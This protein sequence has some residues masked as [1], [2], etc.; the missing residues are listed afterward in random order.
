MKNIFI[1]LL[2]MFA[3][4][5][6]Y[7]EPIYLACNIPSDSG[8]KIFEVRLDEDTGSI[9]HSRD[10]GS[11]FNTEGFFA[12]NSITY[13]NISRSGGLVVIT[14]VYEIDRTD[15][16]IKET[17]TVAPA[18]PTSTVSSSTSELTGS[19]EIKEVSRRQI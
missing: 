3:S 15:L 8:T 7:A 17:F 1:H 2:G 4:L 13:Q 9:T 14:F 18:D 19:C 10:N 6:C 16:S 11:A 12:A 5:S